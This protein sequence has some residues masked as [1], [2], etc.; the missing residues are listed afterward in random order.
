MR[1]FLY[2]V[3]ALLAAAA[4]GGAYS[5]YRGLR[6]FSLIEGEFGFVAAPEDELLAAAAQYENAGRVQ[7]GTYLLC[8]VVFL[9][10]FS[11]MRRSI[12]RLTPDG[13][14]RGP[15]W[16]IGA[17]FIPV[18]CLWMP[19]RI[20][21]DMWAAASPLPTD[22]KPTRVPMWPV[23]LWWGLFAGNV[24]LSRYCA[25]RFDRAE[26]L[27]ALRDALRMYLVCDALEV[28]AA[29]AAVYFAFRLTAL[30]ERKIAQGPFLSGV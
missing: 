10:W 25:Y 12:G 15:G 19:Y 3:S 21:V 27:F 28:V 17:W 24:V 30:Q 5:V 13:F 14:R 6:L 8:A 2:L 23:N 20:A 22:G 7:G 26:N 18:A 9:A 29:G 11:V 4:A 1:W 16:A